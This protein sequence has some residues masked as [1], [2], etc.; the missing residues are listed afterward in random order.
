[1]A[2]KVLI[3]DDDPVSLRLLRGYL[4]K[5]GYEVAQAQNGAAAWSL[6]QTDDF[7]LVIAD[8]MMPEM[9]GLELVRRI[10]SC[11]RQGYAYC[12]LL[13]AR[14]E[15]EDL[16]AGMEAGAD[17]FLG[18][19]FDRDEL[20]VRLREGERI[21]HLERAAR[22]QTE[23]LREARAALAESQRLAQVGRL[24]SQIAAEIEKLLAD[25]IEDLTKLRGQVEEQAAC[26]VDPALERLAQARRGAEQLGKQAGGQQGGPT[27]T[28]PS[29]SDSIE[30]SSPGGKD[31]WKGG[32]SP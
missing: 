30:V 25:A 18:K 20:R 8:W 23:A 27:R 16:V 22:Q 14:A 24:S 10:R 11:Q 15:K 2:V 26:L 31:P 28:G 19:P 21:I 29:G 4:E 1:M 32:K 5:W 13:T 12:I 17:D 3:V 6:F 9:D 7:P